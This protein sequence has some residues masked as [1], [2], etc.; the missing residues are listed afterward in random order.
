MSDKLQF[1]VSTNR[2]LQLQ[3][4][5]LLVVI[6]DIDKLKEALIKSLAQTI[7]MPYTAV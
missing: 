7:G 2:T 1:V 4:Q 5:L 6:S 3:I